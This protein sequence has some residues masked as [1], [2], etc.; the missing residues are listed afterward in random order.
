MVNKGSENGLD[1]SVV[2]GCAR[3]Q[4]D[5][6]CYRITAVQK[7][8]Y[9][10]ADRCTVILGD[11]SGDRLGIC[12]LFRAGVS[13]ADAQD[14]LRIFFQELLDQELRERIGDETAPLRALL[15]AQAFSK[16]NLIDRE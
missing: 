4:L 2:D 5:L 1:F 11:A 16:T 6:R 15:M 7:A 10:V 14:G 9:R 12:V 8:G 13:D 3:M